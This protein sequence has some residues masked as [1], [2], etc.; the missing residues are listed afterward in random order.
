M[1]ASRLTGFREEWL[2]A[3]DGTLILSNGEDES[4]VL[5]AVKNAGLHHE[6]LGGYR[7]FLWHR[8]TPG[9]ALLCVAGVGAPNVELALADV[10]GHGLERVVRYAT[11]GSLAKDLLP[12]D[13]VI[14]REGVAFHDG[15]ASV[16]AGQGIVRTHADSG[17]LGELQRALRAS[18]TKG[19]TGVVMGASFF[20]DPPPGPIAVAYDSML[21]SGSV[22]ALDMET[23]TLFWS[24]RAA[25]V[26]A[27]SVVGVANPVGDHGLDGPA[28]LSG[29]ARVIAQ[30]LR[31]SASK[32]GEGSV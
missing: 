20:H 7:G 31:S 13:V 15:V 1:V 19:R 8:L 5:T 23:G 12:G 6:L 16:G 25:R 9:P 24:A 32:H 2:R 17:L 26:P 18:G 27:G 10:K 14:A 4:E 11:C 21:K 3:A 22:D 30:W 29:G 28:G